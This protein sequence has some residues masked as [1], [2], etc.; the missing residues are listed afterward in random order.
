MKFRVF[1][2][3]I[4]SQ[5]NTDNGALFV[6]VIHRTDMEKW[7][8]DFSAKFKHPV[9]RGGNRNGA[10]SSFDWEKKKAFRT[11]R[12]IQQHRTHSAALISSSGVPRVNY[13]ELQKWRNVYD[14][15]TMSVRSDSYRCALFHSTIQSAPIYFFISFLLR[16]AVVAAD[17]GAVQTIREPVD[18]WTTRSLLAISFALFN[19]SYRTMRAPWKSGKENDPCPP[20][21]EALPPRQGFTSWNVA[22]PWIPVFEKDK[23]T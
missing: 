5:I 18:R 2:K 17:S 13:F 9:A 14:C 16:I 1:I 10:E 12:T 23:E 7:K 8:M 20:F 3:T 22:I 11:R 6:A 15:V 21:P 19:T 4:A